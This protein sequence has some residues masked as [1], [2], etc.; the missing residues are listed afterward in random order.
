MKTTN[1]KQPKSPNTKMGTAHTTFKQV[2]TAFSGAVRAT[3]VQLTKL[4]DHNKEED[5][6]VHFPRFMSS[7]P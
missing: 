3:E 4:W 2:W 7:Q 5:V 6:D 1:S